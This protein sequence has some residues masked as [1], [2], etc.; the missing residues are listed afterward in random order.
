[1]LKP[2]YRLAQEAVRYARQSLDAGSPMAYE[3]AFREKLDSVVA[4][5]RKGIARAVD[6]WESAAKDHGEGTAAW[7]STQRGINAFRRA[8]GVQKPVK[9]KG[10]R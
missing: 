8:W 4:E 6:R 3:A 7:P 10:R 1:M 9:V 5:L 2:T